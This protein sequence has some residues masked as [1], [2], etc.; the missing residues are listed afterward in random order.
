[1]ADLDLLY[2]AASKL[3]YIS[4]LDIKKLLIYD[5]NIILHI[6]LNIDRGFK[7]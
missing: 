6:G 4:Y 7:L 2:I 3:S 1:M 5:I